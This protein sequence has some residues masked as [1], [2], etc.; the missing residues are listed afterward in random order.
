MRGSKPPLPAHAA[1][2]PDALVRTL[3]QQTGYGCG[4][5]GI[6]PVDRQMHIENFIPAD[7]NPRPK[8]NPTAP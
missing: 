5:I 6:L 3:P 1:I 7:F 8:T 2:I 4:A